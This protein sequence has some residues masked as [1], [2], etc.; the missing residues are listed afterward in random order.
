MGQ[1]RKHALEHH[2]YDVSIMPQSGFSSEALLADPAFTNIKDKNILIIRGKSGRSI[3]VKLSYHVV[4]MLN[5]RGIS[6]KTPK[7]S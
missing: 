2:G 1:R 7:Q 3:Y 5:M 4:P 6:A